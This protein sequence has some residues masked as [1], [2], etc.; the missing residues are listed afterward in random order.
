V[1]AQQAIHTPVEQSH[2]QLQAVNQQLEH[3]QQQNHQLR[4]HEQ[5]QQGMGATMTL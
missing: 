1:D 4:L 3:Q 2:Q 5:Q